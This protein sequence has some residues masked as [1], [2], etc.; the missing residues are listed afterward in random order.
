MSN[1]KWMEDYVNGMLLEVCD[2]SYHRRAKDELMNH[3]SEEY[4]LLIERGYEP[5]E[6]RA[7]VTEQMGVESFSFC[8]NP[9][10]DW[11]VTLA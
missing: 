2:T 5:E 11:Y 8:K 10:D 7:K 4:Q 6:A 3:L 1:P 9:S